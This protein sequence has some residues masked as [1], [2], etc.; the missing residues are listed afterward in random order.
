MFSGATISFKCHPYV[1][2]TTVLH[3]NALPIIIR[4][5]AKI[6]DPKNVIELLV[7]T[8]FDIQLEIQIT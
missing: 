4:D 3:D 1:W 7:C 5:Y 6:G 2:S 8:I